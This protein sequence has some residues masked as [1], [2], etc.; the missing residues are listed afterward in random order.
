MFCN[1]YI[2]KLN[3]HNVIL[4]RSR[5][6]VPAK[7]N[8][9]KVIGKSSLVNIHWSN[10]SLWWILPPEDS[11]VNSPVKSSS[12]H[13]LAIFLYLFRCEIEWSL[14]VS[15]YIKQA[16]SKCWL[17]NRKRLRKERNNRDH[18]FPVLHRKIIPSWN[19]QFLLVTNLFVKFLTYANTILKILYFITILVP[20]VARL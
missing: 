3:T 17:Y 11:P 4:F 2:M 14:A 12:T 13:T 7:L 20:L 8:T 5:N 10:S 19:V 18:F 16:K 9:F 15:S 1:D 6:Y